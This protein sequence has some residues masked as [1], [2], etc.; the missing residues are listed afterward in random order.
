MIKSLDQQEMTIAS[1]ENITENLRAS[2]IEQFQLA[3]KNSFLPSRQEPIT[4]NQKKFMNLGNEFFSKNGFSSWILSN[5]LILPLQQQIRRRNRLW[6][7]L[8]LE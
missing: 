1:F 4:I 3:M 6:M 8:P 5:A 7:K 2:Q